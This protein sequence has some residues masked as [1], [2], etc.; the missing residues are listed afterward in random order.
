MKFTVDVEDFYLEKGDLATELQR[1]IKNDVIAQIRETVKKQVADFMD[2]HIRQ[3]IDGELKA[4]VQV[5]MD[6]IIATGKV[7][8]GSYNSE[9]CT[10]ADWIKKEFASKRSDV[11]VAIQKQ[12]AAQIE[13]IKNQYNMYFTTQLIMKIKEQGMLKD[14]AAAMLLHGAKND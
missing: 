5:L 2:Q 4:R 13:E 12:V 8:G 11:M 1:Q 14:D 10:V 3:V 9:E 6:N 7:K